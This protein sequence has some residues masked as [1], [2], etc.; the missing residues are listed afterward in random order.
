MPMPNRNGLRAMLIVA[1]AAGLLATASGRA[2]QRDHL[3]GLEADRI[4][5]AEAPSLRIKLFV[6]F[7]D[8]RLKKFQYELS[9]T[10]P[11]RRRVDR[12]RAL[13]DA[14]AACL[15][16]AVELIDLGIEK[17][18]DIR[19]GVKEVQAKGKEFLAYLEKLAENKTA[20]AAYS[21]NLED[22]IDSTQHALKDAEKAAKEMAPPPVRRR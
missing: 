20:T 16:D 3:T 14:Y 7:A 19:E 17:Q 9:R 11:D 6:L 8:D 15:D 22:A 12:L 1:L 18:Q 13:L 4:R 21:T 2:Q 5:D 10:N